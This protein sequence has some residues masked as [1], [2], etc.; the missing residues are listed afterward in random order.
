MTVLVDDVIADRRELLE[1]ATAYNASGSPQKARALLDDLSP[2]VQDGQLRARAQRLAG[3]IGYSVGR[4]SD[5]A[6]V[7]QAAALGLAGFDPAG[8]RDTMLDALSAAMFGGRYSVGATPVIV[9]RAARSLPR[10]TLEATTISDILLEGLSTFFIDGI[11]PAAPILKQAVD[12][13]E[14]GRCTADEECRLLIYASYAAGAAGD[15][16]RVHRFTTALVKSCRDR[17]APLM[18]RRALHN[19][20]VVESM[21]GTMPTERERLDETDPR[22]VDHDELMAVGEVVPAACRDHEIVARS[23]IAAVIEDATERRQGWI[24]AYADY[25]LAILEL[26]LGNYDPA[27]RHATRASTE[28]HILVNGVLLPDLVEA[29]VRS[30]HADAAI[31]ARDGFEIIA[32]NSQEDFPLGMLARTHALTADDGAAEEFYREAIRRLRMCGA[33]GQLGRAHLVFGEWL[34]R[35]NRRRDAREEL[36]EGLRLFEFVRFEAFA[37]RCR[38]ELAATGERVRRRTDD[39]RDAL[40]TQEAQVARLAALGATNREIASQLFISAATVDYHLRKVFRKLGIDSR[41]SLGRVLDVDPVRFDD[42]FGPIDQRTTR[43]PRS[44]RGPDVGH[45]R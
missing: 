12:W 2:Y 26:G 16:P 34:R 27:F 11:E 39:E 15:M 36:R 19:L 33:H 28:N 9:S 1:V 41:R 29:A 25:A 42:R 3:N 5:T 13:F 14:A 30:G 20:A 8:A 6:A 45:A 4:T 35:Q 22:V 37:E 31:R 17:G 24:L 23:T 38:R 40:T 44:H 7:L 18:L 21:I 43:R 10:P 32:R